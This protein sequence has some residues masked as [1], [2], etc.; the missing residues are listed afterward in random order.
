M[1]DII[2][3]KKPTYQNS[4]QDK[5][6]TA[7]EERMVKMSDYYNH[8]ITQIRADIAGCNIKLASIETNQKTLMWFMFAVIGAL[9]ALFFK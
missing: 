3:M 7:M 4:I 6:L 8:Q 9:I 1:G 5:R 2:T